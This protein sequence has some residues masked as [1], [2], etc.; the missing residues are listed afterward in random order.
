M[1]KRG[2]K[3]IRQL[4]RR[5]AALEKAQNTGGKTEIGRASC[6]ERV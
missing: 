6:R 4:E 5:V 1:S 2:N 3:R